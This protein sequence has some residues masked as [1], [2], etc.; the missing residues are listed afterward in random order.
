MSYTRLLLLGTA[1]ILACSD[2]SSSLA[3]TPTRVVFLTMP[4][5]ATVGN[6][7]PGGVEIGVVDNTGTVNT[8][9]TSSVVIAIGNNPGGAT[10]GGATTVTAVNGIASFTNLTLDQA[11]TGYTLVAT[12]AGLK[13]DTSDAFNVTP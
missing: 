9:A 7:I 6:S 4:A 13:P 3:K 10:L 11:G 2:D 12:S 5:N 8:D 1:A